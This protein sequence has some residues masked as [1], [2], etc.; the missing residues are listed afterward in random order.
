MKGV[1]KLEKQVIILYSTRIF[2]VVK[3]RDVKKLQQDIENNP[4]IW[5]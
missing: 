2:Q 3:I 4:I 1:K 5:N